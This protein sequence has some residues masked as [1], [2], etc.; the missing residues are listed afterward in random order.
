MKFSKEEIKLLRY[1]EVKIRCDD[2]INQIHTNMF[3][4]GCKIHFFSG[5]G[6]EGCNDIDYRKKT[7]NRMKTYLQKVYDL[8]DLTKK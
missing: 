6:G 7:G 8:V 5:G 1:I 4:W 2:C 3:G